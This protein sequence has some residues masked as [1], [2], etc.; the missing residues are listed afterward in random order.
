MI[1]L[2]QIQLLGARDHPKE[3]MRSHKPQYFLA[4]CGVDRISRMDTEAFSVIGLH[5]G[6][7]AKRRACKSKDAND[8]CECVFHAFTSPGLRRFLNSNHGAKLPYRFGALLE[9]CVFLSR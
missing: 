2:Q 9:R 6:I 1:D 5:T 3:S 7:R 4:V 8:H